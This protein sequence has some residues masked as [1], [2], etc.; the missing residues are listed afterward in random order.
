MS[1]GKPVP[2]RDSGNG[3]VEF[4]TERGRAFHIDVR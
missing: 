4:A 2:V 1:D 3:T